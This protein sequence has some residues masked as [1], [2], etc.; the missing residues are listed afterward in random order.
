MTYLWN[1]CILFFKGEISVEAGTSEA[2][3]GMTGF[4][5]D[6]LETQFGEQQKIILQLKD[7]VRERE[8]SIK[9]KEDELKVIFSC[10]L[11]Y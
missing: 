7:L 1:F 3:G 11:N 4:S 2:P 10:A 6:D 8:I 9:D 5:T